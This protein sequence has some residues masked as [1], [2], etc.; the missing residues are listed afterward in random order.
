MDGQLK[1]IEAIR[2]VWPKAKIQRCL[3]HIQRQGL[4]WLRTYPKTEAGKELRLIL[5]Q[6]TGINSL[7]ERNDWVDAYKTWQKNYSDFV[8]SLPR[9]SVAFVD[10]KRAMGLINHALPDMFHYL[11]DR[12][13]PATTN[14]LESFYSRLKSDYQR[15]R[16]MSHK[17]KLAYLKWYCC[18]KNSN[19]F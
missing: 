19:T 16:G 7:K 5:S 9:T 4:Q 14:S 11:K 8:K 18:F 17:H 15:H 12:R 6:V 2:S 3:Y 1:V 10:L 13:I